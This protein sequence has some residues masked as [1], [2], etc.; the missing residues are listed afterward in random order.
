[1]NAPSLA[2]RILMIKEQLKPRGIC[3]TRVLE[4]FEKVPRE[5]FVSETETGHAYEDRP[6]PIGHGQT[7]SQPY[8]VALTLQSLCLEEPFRAL[9]L[10][11]G[12]GYQTALLSLL[13]RSVVSIERVAPL[14]AGARAA[15]ERLGA[16]NITFVVCDGTGG[17]P[18]DRAGFDAIAVSAA[19]PNVPVPLLEQLKPG[20]R[21]VIPVGDRIEQELLLVE[22]SKSGE[23][24]RRALCACR[25]VGL[26]GKYGFPKE[27]GDER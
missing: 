15:L 8:I 18:G 1:M 17:M 7:I 21:M 24:F 19:A 11:T 16:A 10:G 13:C 22:K 14:Q 26:I 9:E 6:L 12:S 23:S 5:W 25:F 27:N 2:A 3:D 4:A 20:G